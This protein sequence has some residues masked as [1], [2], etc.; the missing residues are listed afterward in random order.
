VQYYSELAQKARPAWFTKKQATL[1]KRFDADYPNVRAALAWGLEGP[2]REGNWDYGLR[3]AISLAPFWN[4]LAE[5]NEGKLWLKKVVDEITVHLAESNISFEE[6][7]EL[8]SWKA[9]AL[10]EYGFLIWFQ[11][12]YN[13]ARAIFLECAE[14]FTELKD[15]TGLAHAY[16]F[17]AHSTWGLGEREAA[18]AMWAQAL[19]QFD[20]T[21]DVWGAGM[22]HSFLGRAE[23]EAENYDRAEYHYD[24]C[25]QL[26]EAAGDDW[27]LSIGVSH[28]GMLAFQ[29]NDPAR[30]LSL[31]ER[32]LALSQS[33]GFKQSMAYAIFL[34]GMAA[35]K[36]GDTAQVKKN[37]VEAMAYFYQIGNY[38]TLSESLLGLAWVAAQEGKFERSAWLLGAVMKAD[39]FDRVRMGFEENYFH[40]PLMKELQTSLQDKK[41][42]DVIERGQNATIDQVV[43]EVDRW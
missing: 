31:F 27:G 40:Q 43:A 20:K 3:L 13:Q 1:I 34:M 4:F 38:I 11:S 15:E 22:V 42:H 35:W 25:V 29:R 32:R 23:R 21:G 36:L 19:E 6:R 39:E 26:F 17:L 37:M 8:F 30:A 33:I 12:F 9:K 2:K 28:Q 10:Y 24:R 16:I 14:I 5:N 18:R 7:T 41:F